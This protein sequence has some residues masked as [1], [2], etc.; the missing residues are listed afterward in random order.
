MNSPMMTFSVSSIHNMAT[1]FEF[2]SLANPVFKAYC[3]ASCLLNVKSHL[4]NIWVASLKIRNKTLT[5]PEDKVLFKDSATPISG[6]GC[7]HPDVKRGYQV[8]QN[9]F[10]NFIQFYIIG[11]LYVILGGTSTWPF[12]IFVGARYAHSFILGWGVNPL[13]IVRG[14]AHGMGL[15]S[16]ITLLVGVATKVLTA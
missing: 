1:I 9:D 3:A 14:V 4:T 6:F 15:A 11:A 5:I 2:I 12:Y 8:L 13:G 10:E 7:E 16:S